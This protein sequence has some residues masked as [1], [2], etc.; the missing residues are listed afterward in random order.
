MSQT[1]RTKAG[2]M[3]D[4]ICWL[5]YGRSRG[6]MEIVLEANPGLAAYGPVLPAGVVITLPVV[7]APDAKLDP[8]KNPWS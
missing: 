8:V 1:Y 5:H 4:E 3:V 6:T 7:E 2:D